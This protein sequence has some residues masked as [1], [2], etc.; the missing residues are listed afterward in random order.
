MSAK[1]VL[2][3]NT[4]SII[5]LC[6]KDKR[7]KK[8]IDL[9]GEI[10]YELHEDSYVFLIHEIIE[11]M[12]SIKAGAKIFE[13]LVALCENDIS[14]RTFDALTDDQIKSVGISSSKVS[15]IRALNDAIR[16]GSLKLADLMNMTDDEVISSLTKVKGIGKWT[17][18]MYLIFVLD[19]QNILPI[20]DVAFLQSYKWMYQTND[21]DK[22]NVNKKCRKWAPYSTVASRYLYRALDMGYTKKPF[23]SYV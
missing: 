19:R 9:V 10:T 21:V 20:E 12:L 6:K 13:R 23:A 2:N 3:E 4:E 7:L 5:Y 15:Y 1:I 14:I 11:Q 8:V 16:C 17:A 18:K 22:T